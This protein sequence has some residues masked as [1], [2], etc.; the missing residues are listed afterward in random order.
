MFCSELVFGDIKTSQTNSHGIHLVVEEDELFLQIGIWA[1]IFLNYKHKMWLEYILK[2]FHNQM[3]AM[4]VWTS[5]VNKVN[6]I[7]NMHVCDIEVKLS[8]W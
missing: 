5:Q 8:C 2:L 7:L 6:V 4:N 3:G 1:N